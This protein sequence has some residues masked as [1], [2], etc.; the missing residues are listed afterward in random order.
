MSTAHGIK[1]ITNEI[2]S[3]SQ[4]DLDWSHSEGGLCAL[5][6]YRHESPQTPTPS[7]LAVYTVVQATS[8]SQ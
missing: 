3:I 2:I 7:G 4:V 6:S 1:M 8:K 5:N